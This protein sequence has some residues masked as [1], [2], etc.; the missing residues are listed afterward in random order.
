VPGREHLSHTLHNLLTLHGAL[1]R[2]PRVW[3]GY[4]TETI[5]LLSDDL[6]VAFASHHWPT[7]G[8]STPSS[9]GC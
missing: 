5:G 6:E 3:S 1:V 9:S 7:W 2:E 8:T 4:L